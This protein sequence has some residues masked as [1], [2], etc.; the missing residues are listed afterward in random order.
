V[1]AEEAGGVISKTFQAI[2]KAVKLGGSG[3]RQ[4][5]KITGESGAALQKQFGEDA[6]GVFQKFIVGLQRM[7][8]ENKIL[9]SE[10][11]ILGIEGLRVQKVLPPLAAN[12]SEF[13][14]ALGLA[15]AEVENAT[16]L[17]IEFNRALESGE[18]Q[19]QLLTNAVEGLQREIGDK[20]VRVLKIAGPPLISFIQGLTETKVETFARTTDDV[21]I[22]VKEIEVFRNKITALQGD[23][24][25]SESLAIGPDPRRIAALTE[26]DLLEGL[27]VLQQ[28]ISAI[29]THEAQKSLEELQEQLISLSEKSLDAEPLLE[30]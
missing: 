16:A 15:N 4:L 25:L 1:R 8:G 28:R 6:I 22:L 13:A 19:A 30:G 21:K 3:L 14:R 2:N 26:K 17:N 27:K 23:L 29:K 10:L 7:S 24:S 18:S 12:A 11:K 5:E 20:L 9:S